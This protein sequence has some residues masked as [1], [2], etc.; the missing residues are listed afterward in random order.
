MAELLSSIT[1]YTSAGVFQPIPE[2][3]RQFQALSG[4]IIAVEG[5]IGVGKSTAAQSIVAFLNGIGIEAVCLE[6]LFNKT[7]LGMFY[8]GNENETKPNYAFAFQLSMLK[9]CQRNFERAMWESGKRGGGKR[10]VVVIDR[11]IWGN[12][13]FA[14]LHRQAGNISE[15]EFQSYIDDL[16]SVGPYTID[17]VVYL[18]L[19]PETALRRIAL[20]GRKAERSC[21]I[22]YL[23]ELDRAYYAMVYQQMVS[24]HSNI[25]VISN[26]IFVEPEYVLRAITQR[27]RG[28]FSFSADLRPAPDM[29]D[30]KIREGFEKL[31]NWYTEG[32]NSD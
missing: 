24:R 25:T 14:A 4:C 9:D 20:R 12:A 32:L 23:R 22:E 5:G 2:L 15:K 16:K 27:P 6:E 13:V 7:L 26:D 3:V 29:T 17:Y 31:C 30:E 1:A 11:T 10:K 18:D 8:E 21:K 19:S 28:A